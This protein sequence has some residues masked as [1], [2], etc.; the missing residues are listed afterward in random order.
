[1]E[2][3]ISAYDITDLDS[4][5]EQKFNVSEEYGNSLF[6]DNQR[7]DLN[8]YDYSLEP[9]TYISIIAEMQLQINQLSKTVEQLKK[10]TGW[11]SGYDDHGWDTS[12]DKSE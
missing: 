1:M 7:I 8:N 3:R 9:Y 10:K 2:L 4:K 12:E 5:I 6:D 11:V